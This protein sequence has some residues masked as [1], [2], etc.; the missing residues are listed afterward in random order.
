MCTAFLF[1]SL[2]SPETEAPYLTSPPKKKGFEKMC[3]LNPVDYP[4]TSCSINE[5]CYYRA[6]PSEKMCR[7]SFNVVGWLIM[8]ISWKKQSKETYKYSATQ[9]GCQGIVPPSE[10]NGWSAAVVE[11]RVRQSETFFGQNVVLLLCPCHIK[12]THAKAGY[13]LVGRWLAEGIGERE[14]FTG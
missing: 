3:R 7:M 1:L 11:E 5:T 2:S 6:L 14:H 4:M 8:S 13:F 9:S 10:C 12:S